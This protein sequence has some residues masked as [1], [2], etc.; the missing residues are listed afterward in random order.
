MT[1]VEMLIEQHVR[2]ASEAAAAAAAA[3]ATAAGAVLTG[4][5]AET[6][7]WI[8]PSAPPSSPPSLPS[9]HGLK[10]AISVAAAVLDVPCALGPHV[11]RRLQ[12]AGFCCFPHFFA[13]VLS[14]SE[15]S[16]SF[17]PVT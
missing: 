11:V 8:G 10:A 7:G 15:A 14:R 6:T 17:A 1:A 3:V 9:S 13:T 5:A 16:R 12:Q 2:A 4:G